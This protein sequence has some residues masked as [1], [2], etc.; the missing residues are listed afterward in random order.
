MHPALCA[1]VSRLSYESRLH[2]HA[3]DRRL[4][5]VEPGLHPVPI[6]HA[7]NSTASVEE[8]AAVVAQVD[9][10]IGMPWTSDGV[11]GPL[12]ETDIII[13]AP[14]NAQVELI[15]N[16]LRSAGHPDVP[17]GTVDMFQG[18]EAAIAI[19]SLAASAADDVPR[20]LEFLLLANRLNVAI[21]R[22]QWAA[23]LIYSPAL[24]EH[25]PGS[26]AGLAQLSA[27]I[28]LVED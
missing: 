28:R 11:T 10:L 25:L 1:P 19:V 17:V 15:R 23:Y 14:Y 7:G 20:G 5:G 8:A 24:T 21:S 3:S 12:T 18:K 22:A 26:I 13:V 16:A 27:F 6:V 4:A 2:S 9:R